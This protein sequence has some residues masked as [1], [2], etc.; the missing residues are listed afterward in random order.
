MT[1]GYTFSQLEINQTEEII[2]TV[3]QQDIQMFADITG[4]NNP[5]HLD[6]EFAATTQFKKPIAHGMFGAGL[7]SAVIGTKLPGPGC[8]YLDQ[9]LKFRAPIYIDSEITTRVTVV[10]KNERR[11]R[12]T[13]KTECLC[14]DKVVISGQAT[15]M[16]N[17]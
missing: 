8:I 10:E 7:I 13:L 2:R 11:R 9:E 15:V 5:V 3:S 1:T 12:V 14:E 17:D 4:D 6:A 16:V